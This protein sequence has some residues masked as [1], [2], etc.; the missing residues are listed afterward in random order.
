[1]KY[2]LTVDV[3]STI[4]GTVPAACER[5]HVA[6]HALA[7][8]HPEPTPRDRRRVR[9]VPGHLTADLPAPA[10]RRPW[11]PESDPPQARRATRRSRLQY[12]RVDPPTFTDLS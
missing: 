10:A 8:G 11:Y 5:N 1:M 2:R 6:I 9:G 12:C 4:L 7:Q 3:P